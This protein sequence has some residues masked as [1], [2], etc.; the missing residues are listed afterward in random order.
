MVD[1]KKEGG[2]GGRRLYYAARLCP[3]RLTIADLTFISVFFGNILS[4]E[5]DTL[6]HLHF[7]KSRV[8]ETG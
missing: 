3:S 8:Q 2:I 7:N 6:D 5:L 4:C 1:G